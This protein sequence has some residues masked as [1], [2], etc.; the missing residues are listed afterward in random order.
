MACA[1]AFGLLGVARG[2]LVLAAAASL[3][4]FFVKIS[5]GIVTAALVVFCASLLP[6]AWSGGSPGKRRTLVLG[7]GAALVALGIELMATD[8]AIGLPHSAAEQYESNLPEGVSSLAE[9]RFWCPDLLVLLAAALL[10]FGLLSLGDLRRR[11]RALGEQGRRQRLVKSVFDWVEDNRVQLFAWIV[12]LATL[13]VLSRMY[14][15]PRYLTLPLI[16]LWFN[17]GLMAFHR[18]RWNVVATV[19]IAAIVAFN[20]LN[21]E[22][23]FYP[24]ATSYDRFDGRTGAFLERSREYLAD[25]RANIEL[26]NALKR[27][28]NGR[29]I[30]TFNP[31]VHFLSLPSLGYV[32]AP[33][34]GYAANSF[35]T[36]TF[37]PVARLRQD[38]PQDLLFA[39]AANRFA[40]LAQCVF[41]QPGF[42][43]RVLYAQGGVGSLVA[44]Q[45]GALERLDAVARKN[46]YLQM[47]WP[48]DTLVEE[49]ERLL[50][51]GERS[52]A[53]EAYLRALE[54]EPLRLD[55]R[56]RLV[57]LLVA[58]GQ[59]D[60]A[61]AQCR[62]LLE[63]GSQDVATHKLMAAILMDAGRFSEAVEHAQAAIAL[64]PDDADAYVTLGVIEGR[65]QRLERAAAA[66]RTAI[67]YQPT[68]A[69]A[70]YWLG[71]TQMKQGDE[72]RALES[73]QRA[74]A[75]DPRHAEA[76]AALAD[77]FGKQGDDAGALYHFRQALETRP[78]WPEIVNKAAWLL[79]TN[80]DARLR[81]GEEAVRLAERLRESDAAHPSYLD[82]LAAAYAEAGRFDEAVETA[83]RALE[84]AHREGRSELARRI[85]QRLAGYRLK[86]PAHDAARTN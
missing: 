6:L 18:L 22:G 5:G 17:V 65:G 37:P 26:V 39:W 1:A 56:R 61:L 30:V 9:A 54:R 2:R 24:P 68:S 85:E 13:A 10:T 48:G 77:L 83:Q 76:H 12:I 86:K 49:A 52:A 73:L 66:F 20:L 28:A 53:I 36:E 62:F 64:K 41:P 40:P 44:F 63:Q 25:H 45:V 19:F 81:D 8:W 71:V 31:F 75:L 57:D 7:G 42:G 3:L 32:D 84:A 46:R 79:A 35:H 50:A 16:F 74:V 51:V 21:M 15:I 23:R 67:D 60:A 29:R 80:P 4:A 72:A 82:T 47:L 38:P 33:L 55:V 11:C 34:A 14:T 69:A 27:E 70:H 59:H 58:A 43:D 78:N